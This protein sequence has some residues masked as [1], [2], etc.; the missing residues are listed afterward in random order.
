MKNRIKMNNLKLI[1]A[2]ILLIA[3][4]G[5]KAQTSGE[6]VV[7]LSDPAKRAVVNID[8]RKGSIT[9]TG[10]S[11]KDVKIFYKGREEKKNKNDNERDG[12]TKISSGGLD[13]E[14]YEKDNRISISSDSWNKAIDLEI[15]IPINSDLK[16]E[17]YNSGDL[18]VDNVAGEVTAENYNGKITLMNISGS[19][20]AS[21][22]NGEIKVLLN[23]VTPDT[24]MS[25]TTYNGNV[26]ITMPASTKGNLKLRSARG[27]IYSGFDMQ[28][29]KSEAVQKKDDSKGV[30]RV[31]LD[32]WTKATING[33]GP[34]ITMK[35]NNGDIYIRTK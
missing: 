33:G 31:Y 27:D 25:F 1:F 15:E 12:L 23:K 21:T 10:T 22:Y 5:A 7:P 13:L 35:N 26:D 9:V 18:F 20:V 11:R 24:P 28:V 14:A 3:F 17:T 16:L 29:S 34:D 4:A 30:Y 2:V 8:I 19:A 6:I 32:D